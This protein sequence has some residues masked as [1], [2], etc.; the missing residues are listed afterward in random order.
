M[1]VSS[2]ML[3]TFGVQPVL[4]RWFT[5][6][7]CQRG[8]DGVALL[9]YTYWRDRFGLS[10]D[11]LGQEIQLNDRVHK[12]I[13]VMP[14]GFFVISRVYLP[15]VFD[16]D[17]LSDEARSGQFGFVQSWAKLK[18]GVSIGEAR[19]NM[20]ALAANL[21]QQYPVTNEDRSIE[22]Y[23]PL[24]RDRERFA[25]QAVYYVLPALF[26]ILIVCANVA[27][28][29]LTRAA[30]RQK[31]VAIRAAMGAGRWRIIRQLLIE[32]IILAVIG[33]VLG[34]AVAYIG[35]D[36][37]LAIDPDRT[38]SRTE[39]IEVDWNALS[40]AVGLSGVSGIL[41][42]LAPAWLG[43]RTNLSA[44]LKEGTTRS[45][46][47]AG[48]T[49]LR[50]ALI[51]SEIALTTML[52]VGAGLM[53]RGLWQAVEARVGFDTR[54]VTAHTRIPSTEPLTPDGG[55]EDPEQ[56]RTQSTA[57][58]DQALERLR[59]IP[60]V[61]AAA[62][63]APLTVGRPGLMIQPIRRASTPEEAPTSV[64]FRYV[65]PGFFETLSIPILRGRVLDDGDRANSEL[66]AVVSESLAKQLYP[67]R[68]PL[69][70]SV[71]HARRTRVEMREPWRIIGVVGDIQWSPLPDDPDPPEIYL[72][73]A[74][75]P[76]PYVSF[77]IKAGS[78]PRS[79]INPVRS[80]LLDL[81]PNQP[82][83]GLTTIDEQLTDTIRSRS[84]FPAVMITFALIAVLLAAVGIYG[85][86]SYSVS[87]RT[88][89]LGI[90][91]ALGAQRRDI[92]GMVI[93]Q[94]FVLGGLGI[95][96]GAAG[97]WALIRLLRSELTEAQLRQAG[98]T[99]VDLATCFVVVVFLGL[100]SVA[101]N[102]LPARRA[103][104]V[105]PMTALRYE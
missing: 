12:I 8:N 58:T 40:F 26:V 23:R 30:D 90:R 105:E 68:N 2:G 91:M 25:D 56:M 76:T 99:S 98:L 96:L 61:R 11:V 74:Q 43:S 50:Q 60:G 87:R 70:E 92:V 17:E 100:V 10:N 77:A 94:G 72:S 13:G 9:H 80:A 19:A 3:P 22:I 49:R 28:L 48:G 73:L 97:S 34:I 103:T 45:S 85:L 67:S 7:E 54:V 95:S 71:A 81:N 65:T 62:G 5:R 20:T 14:P 47:A 33:G 102:Y 6:E 82:V 83:L 64:A 59:A 42:G 86:T 88:Q 57:F 55:F 44:V 15:L 38:Y 69:G 104:R 78:E 31:E 29:Q 21:E 1:E 79:I 32:N 93:R 46:A 52:L 27:H 41:F 36:A 84:L 66:V 37:I 51:V 18:P 101:A 35:L 63:A 75:S 16:D 53:L 24:D 89:E 39:Y 4:G